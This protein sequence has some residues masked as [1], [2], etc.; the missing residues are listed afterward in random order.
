MLVELHGR[1]WILKIETIN[2]EQG[3]DDTTEEEL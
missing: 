2:E 3:P 1:K